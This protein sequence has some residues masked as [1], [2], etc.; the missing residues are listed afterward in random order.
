MDC[1]LQAGCVLEEPGD[2]EADGDAVVD[3][4]HE[5][6]LNDRNR[7][8]A[9]EAEATADVAA[10]PR[11]EPVRLE[12]DAVVWVIAGGL[13]GVVRARRRRG[14]EHERREGRSA[15]EAS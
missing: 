13:D 14:R 6:I 5:A 9:A 3:R 10:I 7:E 11:E 1:V 8:P 2:A 12:L 15:G 4:R